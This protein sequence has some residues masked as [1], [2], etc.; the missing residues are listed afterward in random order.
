MHHCPICSCNSEHACLAQA[1]LVPGSRYDLIE[2]PDCGVIRLDP[3]PTPEVLDPVAVLKECRRIIKPGGRFF[4]SVPN[5]TND[6]RGLVRFHDLEG[7]PA[8][9]FSGHTF[10]F[11]ARTMKRL[12]EQTGFRIARAETGSIKRGMRN[13]GWLPSKKKWK[14]PYRLPEAT[15]RP[16]V[17]PGGTSRKPP[18]KPDIY[19][20]FRFIQNTLNVLPGLHDFG[21]DFIF[22]LRPTDPVDHRT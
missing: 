16:Q 6:H 21:L 10:F 18:K 2:C 15:Q 12:L 17:L 7:K 8:R 3:M 19:Y 11:P 13:C 4:L 5:G 22:H 1:T 9:S 20:R 14:D